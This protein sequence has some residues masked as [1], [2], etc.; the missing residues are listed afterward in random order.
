MCGCIEKISPYELRISLPHQNIGYVPMTMISDEYTELVQQK[1]SS[2]S[3]NN[4]D[5]DNLFHIGQYVICRVIQGESAN[6]NEKPNQKKRLHLS[7]D[8]K[9]VCDQIAPDN[10]VKGMVKK[11]LKNCL[12]D[13][14]DISN[15]FYLVLYRVLLI[16]VLLLILDFHK[17]KVSYLRISI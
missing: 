16:M 13:I 1:M 6:E 5:L 3:T 11:F 9:D 8:P 2:M 15:R 10:L 17:E 12:K 14:D 4:D 7:I